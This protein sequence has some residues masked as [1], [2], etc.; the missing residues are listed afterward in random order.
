M[1]RQFQGLVLN[2]SVMVVTNPVASG[3]KIR[4]A[5]QEDKTRS[6]KSLLRIFVRDDCSGCVD[7]QVC[8]IDDEIVAFYGLALQIVGTES[9]TPLKKSTTS[10]KQMFF[11]AFPGPRCRR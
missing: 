2:S 5:K 11:R 6:M 3:A 8:T 10:R 7:G 9:G 4:S 1:S